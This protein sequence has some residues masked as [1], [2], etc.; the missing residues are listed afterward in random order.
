[1]GRT[2]E[3]I[4][5]YMPFNNYSKS[6]LDKCQ[7][8]VG[9]ML[10]NNRKQSPQDP[11]YVG[12]GRLEDGQAVRIEGVGKTSQKGAQMLSFKIVKI[13][14]NVYDSTSFE[15]E[16]PQYRPNTSFLNGNQG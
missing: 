10:V 1:M 6:F 7:P 9:N 3:Q 13:P 12:Y 14:G 11:D 16:V 5:K 8:G 2:L 4:L 15:A